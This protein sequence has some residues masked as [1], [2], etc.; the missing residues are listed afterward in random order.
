M[1]DLEKRQSQ[2]QLLQQNLRSVRHIAGWTA[3][4]LG[5]RIGVTKQT[6]G[7]LENIKRPMNLTQYLAIRSILNDEIN[8]T[9]DNAAVLQQAIEILVDKGAELEEGKYFEVKDTLETVAA[10][11]S[12]GKKGASLDKIF[13]SLLKATPGI[14]G[15]LT[16]L[17]VVL[18]TTDRNAK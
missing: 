9:S 4:Q 2:T 15:A 7:D 16:A 13:I 14:V 10:S 18:L 12:K 1:N 11:A 17:G 5:E 3:E 8:S 6:V